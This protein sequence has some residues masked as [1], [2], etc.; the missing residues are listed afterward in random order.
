MGSGTSS[1][2]QNGNGNDNEMNIYTMNDVKQ[3]NSI[4]NGLWIILNGFVYDITSFAKEHPGGLSILNDVAGTDATDEFDAAL[5]SDNAIELTKKYLIGKL[6]AN[7]NP[8][9]KQENSNENNESKHSD[10]KTEF[11]KSDI[12]IL[13]GTQTGKSKK[14]SEILHKKLIEIYK[15]VTSIKLMDM[16]DYDA[17]DLNNENICI[18]IVS[19]YEGGLPPLNAQYFINWINDAINDYRIPDHYLNKVRYAV[20]GLGNSLYE[21]N[22]NKVSQQLNKNLQSLS[23][24]RI[25]TLTLGDNNVSRDDGKTIR[26]DFDDFISQILI[27][28]DKCLKDKNYPTNIKRN[29]NDNN[30]DMEDVGDIYIGG[31]NKTGNNVSEGKS[32]TKP[33]MVNDMMR[34]SL[35]KQGYK[36]I[37]S[38]SGVKLCRWTKSML[39]GRGGCYK[40]TFYGIMSFQC[41]EVTPS[42]AC[43]NKCT[44]CWRHHTNPVGKEWKW[45]TDKPEFILDTAINEHKKMVKQ[46]KGVPGVKPDRLKEASVIRHCALSL[47]GEPIMY[48]HINEYLSLLHSKNISSFLVTNAQFPDRIKILKPVTQLYVSVDAPTKDALKK[49]DRPLFKDFWRR[50]IDCLKEIRSKKQRTVYRLTLVKGENMDNIADYARLIGIGLPS[51]I[52]VK[53]VTFCGKSDGSNITMDNIPFHFEVKYFVEK[54]CN[55]LNGDYLLACEHEHSCCCLIAHKKFKINNEWHTWIDYDKWNILSNSNKEFS[56]IDYVKKTPN[57]AIWNA[58]EGGFNPNETRYIKNKKK[59]N[60]KLLNK[61]NKIK[62]QIELD[63]QNNNNNNINS[64]NNID[65]YSQTKNNNLHELNL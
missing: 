13:Y 22:Y 56:D 27:E 3:H 64:N 62:N 55:Y 19:T 20:F 57:W 44:F 49:V 34:K 37:G 10:K 5:H 24:K 16:K 51:F 23:G 54:L 50:F 60:D 40:H 59:N 18:F 61:I 8:E 53:G 31:K 1:E 6:K 7:D 48:P 39:R 11:I 63:K 36:V 52:E 25:N 28:I 41:M 12:T 33:E 21:S 14:Y 46:M 65:P 42:L 2:E 9:I 38:H 47:V 58:K 15:D 29:N 17:E 30:V 4:H 35:T 43:A 45:V 26:D 32:D